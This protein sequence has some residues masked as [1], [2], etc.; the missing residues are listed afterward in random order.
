MRLVAGSRGWR[1]ASGP[2]RVASRRERPGSPPRSSAIG[3]STRRCSR[4][5]RRRRQCLQKPRDAPALQ[6]RQS[7]PTRE[8]ALALADPTRRARTGRA[9]R[10]PFARRARATIARRVP[11]APARRRSVDRGSLDRPVRRRSTGDTQRALMVG[12]DGSAVDLGAALRQ[13]HVHGREHD[14]QHIEQR[15]IDR[16]V[17]D[18]VAHRV[19]GGSPRRLARRR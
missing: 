11:T 14:P 8:A 5:R 1:G 3:P 2:A 12:T 4:R 7:P 16:P 6:R 9:R 18:R 10:R 15:T 19:R 17:A 13:Q